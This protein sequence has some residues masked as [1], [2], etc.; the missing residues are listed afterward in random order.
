MILYNNIDKGIPMVTDDNKLEQVQD[1][2][3]NQANPD[4][5]APVIEKTGTEELETQEVMSATED[6][7]KSIETAASEVEVATQKVSQAVDLVN[8]NSS[9]K[10]VSEV[11]VH[12]MVENFR[13]ITNDF[14][15]DNSFNECFAI[16][17]EDD[18]P[19]MGR[20]ANV[21]A[22]IKR[23]ILT[24]IK[25][26]K[27]KLSAIWKWTKDIFKRS[28]EMLVKVKS[29]VINNNK[30]L[31]E[32]LAENGE[33]KGIDVDRNKI[34][35]KIDFNIFP[36]I[37]YIGI[38]DNGSKVGLD[39]IIGHCNAGQ[40]F[41][42]NFPIIDSDLTFGLAAIKTGNVMEATERLK[43]TVTTVVSNIMNYEVNEVDSQNKKAF[44]SFAQELGQ[45]NKY[46]PLSVSHNQ[47][48]FLV[49]NELT[50]V[51][52]GFSIRDVSIEVDD[53]DKNNIPFKKISLVD[54]EKT[55]SIFQKAIAMMQ[56]NM[57]TVES[58]IKRLNDSYEYI[59]DLLEKPA[60]NTEDTEEAK[61]I[62]VVIK[63]LNASIK[64]IVM[65]APY[66]WITSTLN[67]VYNIDKFY[68]HL[69]EL[70]KESITVKTEA[71]NFGLEFYDKL[72]PTEFRIDPKYID[73]ELAKTDWSSILKAK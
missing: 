3:P 68:M 44:G 66:K 1:I 59:I 25:F 22:T 31:N 51:E 43:R 73:P 33:I 34:I 14:P 13:Y 70:V 17:K 72:R 15:I 62:S 52:T 9:K 21:L 2:D 71:V 67:F 48:G 28:G 4:T 32:F 5:T 7:I 49:Y 54:I 24:A 11:D 26:I 40:L 46:W 16:A 41:L 27:E 60:K 29:S 39:G 61:E 23:W 19:P 12:V 53:S 6:E 38:G 57:K 42:D 50:V 35:D 18:L 69:A 56:A 65:I 36:M 47:I 63:L 8:D 30:K 37:K 20:F 55:S 45:G 64:P 10:D 58:Y